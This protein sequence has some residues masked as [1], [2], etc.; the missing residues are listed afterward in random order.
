MDASGKP[1]NPF[2]RAIVPFESQPQASGIYNT[3]EIIVPGEQN[4]TAPGS[5]FPERRTPVTEEM[6]SLFHV[7]P[8]DGLPHLE[9][10][11]AAPR[12]DLETAISQTHVPAMTLRS[13]E[14][15][16]G[17]P[18][19]WHGS[20]NARLY[21]MRDLA[22]IHWLNR[23]IKQNNTSVYLSVQELA[24]L[25][26]AYSRHYNANM[27]AALPRQRKFSELHESLLRAI[28]MMDEGGT[29]RILNEAFDTYPAAT[30]CQQVLQ[31]VLTKLVELRH[32]VSLPRTIEHFAS[33]LTRDQI[34]H[35]I[36][37]GLTPREALQR[38]SHLALRAPQIYASQ[39][40][41]REHMDAVPTL[42]RIVDIMLEAIR[43]LDEGHVQRIMDEAFFYYPVEEVCSNLFQPV[44]YR[45]GELWASRQITVTV[46][47][48]ASNMIRT[49]LAHLFQ[50]TPY[51]HQGPAILV[52]CAPRETHEIGILMLAL[53]WR[54][55]G[56]NVYYLGQML[57]PQSLLQEIRRLRP[58]VVCLSAT[59]RPRA[60]DL[61]EIAREINKLE[62]PRPTVCFGGGAFM[63][64]PGLVKSIKGVF[65][66]PD[67]NE[68][69]RR[70][71]ELIP[72]QQSQPARDEAH[73]IM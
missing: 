8:G 17:I 42:E 46:E 19:P 47:H 43:Q 34:V 2:E 64:D 29:G 67:A 49:R 12:F 9:R 10:Y 27:P 23:R 60:R 53:F 51:Q 20:N 45:I 62:G 52:G 54:R 21:S 71:H 13:W 31:P 50:T 6:F 63:Q 32:T 56:F 5:P 35:L 15:R 28:T 39:Q 3:Q 36:E 25:E 4:E 72:L 24:R 30:V 7:P 58:G 68:A 44:L 69:T 14:R 38:L 59:T 40:R 11:S 66:G 22:A 33:K 70:L 48:F 37:A 65:L 55:Q 26:P 18:A 16:F 57:E 73:H 41:A 61:A 1:F